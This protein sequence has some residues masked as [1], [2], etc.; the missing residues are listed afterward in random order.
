MYLSPGKELSLFHPTLHLQE[1]GIIIGHSLG[2]GLLFA[3]GPSLD[4]CFLNLDVQGD[5]PADW[6]WTTEMCGMRICISTASD[7]LP[8]PAQK[9]HTEARK[10]R[11]PHERARMRVAL[12]NSPSYHWL[13]ARAAASARW[14]SSP[15]PLC[16]HS[17]AFSL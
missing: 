3:F 14:A 17:P 15:T 11:T 10:V 12:S 8:A 6:F 13:T 7:A 5:F 16:W 9:P 2:V 4:C 1:E